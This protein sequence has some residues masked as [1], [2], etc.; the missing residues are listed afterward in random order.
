MG[1][2]ARSLAAFVLAV[3][4]LAAGGPVSA[5]NWSQHCGSGWGLLWVWEDQNYA[6]DMDHACGSDLNW[7]TGGGITGLNDRM[8][9]LHAIDRPGDGTKFCAR[10]FDDADQGGN[11]WVASGGPIGGGAEQKDP[12]VGPWNDRV[13]SHSSYG[14][15]G[16]TC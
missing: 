9:S 16:S 3:G 4:L 11:S 8:T 5:H 1:H 15:T 14:T 2:A 6:G 13:S 12:N 10:M 7:G